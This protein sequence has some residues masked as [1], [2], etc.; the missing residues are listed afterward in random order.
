MKW[1]FDV[2]NLVKGRAVFVVLISSGDTPVPGQVTNRTM[3][4]VPTP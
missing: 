1:I 3:P 2:M 4:V